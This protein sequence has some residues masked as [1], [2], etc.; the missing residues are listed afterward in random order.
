LR[1]QH[2][3]GE[4]VAIRRSFTLTGSKLWSRENADMHRPR[5]S[6]TSYLRVV[7]TADQ[8]APGRQAAVNN[9]G[10]MKGLDTSHDTLR[11]RASHRGARIPPQKELEVMILRLLDGDRSAA[12][13]RRLSNGETFCDIRMIKPLKRSP[14]PNDIGVR[15]VITTQSAPSARLYN[16]FDT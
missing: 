4:D 11:N 8:N 3:D 6:E 9:P 10:R 15:A 5:A 1:Q 7:C 14:L 16:T 13:A 12:I 2:P